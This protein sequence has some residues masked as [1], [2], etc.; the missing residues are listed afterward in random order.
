MK[1]KTKNKI[2]NEKWKWKCKNKMMNENELTWELMEGSNAL[3][4][5]IVHIYCCNLCDSVNEFICETPNGY[6]FL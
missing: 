5:H 3:I 1:M 4:R 2:I 6:S